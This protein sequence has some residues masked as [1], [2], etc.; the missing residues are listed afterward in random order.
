VGFLAQWVGS[1]AS[2]LGAVVAGASM[3]W[4]GRIRALLWLGLFH[5]AAA[6]TYAWIAFAH[7]TPIAAGASVRDSPVW[8]WLVLASASEHLSGAMATTALFTL[9]MDVSNPRDGGTH[10]TIQ[11][12]VVVACQLG[13]GAVSG[14][15]AEAMGLPAFFLLCAVLCVPAA[16]AALLLRRNALVRACLPERYL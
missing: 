14:A 6:G 9:M 1:A 15:V 10:Y 16:C 12:S 7:A 4:M 8:S 3:R 13:S 5:A 11:A 2:I